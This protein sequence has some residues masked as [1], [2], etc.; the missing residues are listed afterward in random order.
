MA[1]ATDLVALV[2]QRAEQLGALVDT[3]RRRREEEERAA[4]VSA[5]ALELKEIDAARAAN[6]PPPMP[7]ILLRRPSCVNSSSC[8]TAD[9][10]MLRRQN[11][12][13]RDAVLAA[14]QR[15]AA[16]KKE[17][18]SGHK[19]AARKLLPPPAPLPGRARSAARVPAAANR[20]ELRKLRAEFAV[21]QQDR[22]VLQAQEAILQQALSKVADERRAHDPAATGAPRR[23]RRR[24]P[25]AGA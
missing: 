14:D 15:N 4:K 23:R 13:L 17:L 22:L 5:R 9:L 1:S 25:E 10:A 11:R 18:E 7:P 6:P 8:K 2:A 20:F 3:E 12:Q 19:T 21:A 24:P 16:H